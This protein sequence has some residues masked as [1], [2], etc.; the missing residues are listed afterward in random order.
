MRCK[1]CTWPP[2]ERSALT[3]LATLMSMPMS[4]VPLE[5]CGNLLIA[6]VKVSWL[7]PL[8]GNRLLCKTGWY[9]CET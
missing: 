9:C 1:A 4:W 5:S 3:R 2:A 6:G 8:H 7:R